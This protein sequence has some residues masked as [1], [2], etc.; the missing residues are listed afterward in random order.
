[1]E[2]KRIVIPF[3]LV[4]HILYARQRPKPRFSDEASNML[5]QYYV[6]IAVKHGSPRI[7]ETVFRIAATIAKLKLKK[8]V[9]EEDARETMQ[10]YNVILQQIEMIVTVPTNPRDVTYEECLNVLRENKWPVAF[11][12]VIK[13]ACERNQQVS[14]YIGQNFELSQNHKLRPIRD[15]LE[16]HSRI[17]IVQNTPLVFVYMN[18]EK[19]QKQ[20]DQ[21]DVSDV[22]TVT[23][24]KISS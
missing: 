7:R 22:P 15:M 13:T 20:N 3:Y 24:E 9:D 1:L 12:E 23:T 18:A 16:N 2:G 5:N 6:N 10:F 19:E 21:N 11:E 4:K 8:I 14:H 17:K